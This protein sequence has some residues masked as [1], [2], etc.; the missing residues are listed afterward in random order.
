MGHRYTQAREAGNLAKGEEAC[1]GLPDRPATAALAS[2][3]CLMEGFQWGRRRVPHPPSVS[4]N[5]HPLSLGSG[6]WGREESWGDRALAAKAER[7]SR[8][9]GS[10]RCLQAGPLLAALA[11]PPQT[12]ALGSPAA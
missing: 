11:G 10:T 4:P 8:D 3:H 9:K 2:G 7:R 1:V 5:S 12:P 6:Q